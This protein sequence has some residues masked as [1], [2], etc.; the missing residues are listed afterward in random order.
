MLD[1]AALDLFFTFFG[2][3]R[4]L[5]LRRILL[6]S[7]F[8][9]APPEPNEK[10][11]SSPSRSSE[12]AA[13]RHSFGAAFVAVLLFAC[14]AFVIDLRLARD[15]TVL[16]TCLLFFLPI[17]GDG[18]VTIACRDLYS[19]LQSTMMVARLSSLLCLALPRNRSCVADRR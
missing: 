13:S 19:L 8:A 4:F 11:P 12:A 16:P 10:A 17:G 1:D 15:S 5:I 14:D 2:V 3:A 7:R 6:A 18:A 9:R